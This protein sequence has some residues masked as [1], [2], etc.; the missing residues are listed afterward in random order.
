M[1]AN[2]RISERRLNEPVT[3]LDVENAA[4]RATLSLFGGQLLSFTPAQDGRERLFLSRLA[5]L[6]GSKSIRGGVPV[7]W[8]WFGAHKQQTGLP[9]H[10]YARTRQ[11]RLVEACES[12][13]ETVLLLQA[14]DS[15]GPGFSGA[16]R[17]QLQISIGSSVELQLLTINT[18]QHAFPL[19]CALHTYFAVDDIHRTQL[20]GL[21]GQYSDKT[22]DWAHFA[23]PVPYGF[24]EETDRI[25]LQPSAQVDIVQGTRARTRVASSG[26]DSIVVWNP[27]SECARNF[28]DLAADDYTRML[29]V[30]TA[31]TQGF[32]LAPGQTHALVQTIS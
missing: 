29:C 24:S 22:R 25:H 16:A 20:E 11:W 26:H 30:E 6:D 2:C 1:S 21:Q 12:A 19:S 18:G 4:G 14:E 27:W 8:P 17:L 10:G 7:C 3:L 23:T 5:R 32:E 28:P 31:L 13:E 15:T 9:A